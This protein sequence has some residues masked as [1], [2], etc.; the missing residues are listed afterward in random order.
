VNL[1]KLAWD[2]ADFADHWSYWD[3]GHFSPIQYKRLR[4]LMS[5]K[6]A[7]YAIARSVLHGMELLGSSRSRR[8]ISFS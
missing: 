3:L 2:M 1:S 6:L 7:S 4:C 8:W 5:H